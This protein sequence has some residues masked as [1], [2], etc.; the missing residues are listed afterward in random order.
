[1]KKF[2]GLMLIAIFT[3]SCGGGFDAKVEE[4]K[5]LDIH[6]EVMPKIGEVMSLR[7]QVLA[8]VSEIESQNPQ[9]ETL[10]DLRD[11]AAELESANDGMM[12]WMNDWS[13]S[14]KPHVNGTSSEEE[15][16]AFFKAEMERVTK[17]KEDINTS[18]AK[19]K[20]VLK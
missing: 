18:M 5:V 3:Y 12:S 20:K 8:K 17:V 19:A 15:Q 7:R 9:N 14:K 4:N 13:K 2:L 11:L 16:I 6:D 1:M 10:K